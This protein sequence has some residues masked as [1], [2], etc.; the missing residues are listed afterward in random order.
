MGVIQ[1]SGIV[2]LCILTF[3]ALLSLFSAVFLRGFVDY[4]F[5]SALFC[6]TIGAFLF[7]LEGGFFQAI[8]FSFKNYR[9]TTKEGKYIAKFD[10]LD[11]TRELYEEQSQNKPYKWTSPLLAG[12]GF[13]MIVTLIIA[14][15]SLP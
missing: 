5:L 15:L 10:N 2:I 1:L 8:R 14:F 4:A 6:T 9:K 3:S 11:D 12:G 7:V 13:M